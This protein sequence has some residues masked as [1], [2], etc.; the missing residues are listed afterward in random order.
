MIGVDPIAGAAK[1]SVPMS[2]G[3]GLVGYEA[4]IAGDGYAYVPYSYVAGQSDT[5]VDGSYPFIRELDVLRV[6]SSGA[7]DN[8]V[9]AQWTD[10]SGE[11]LS[12]GV[13]TITN[14]DQGV[15]LSWSAPG[16]AAGPRMAMVTGTT[17]AP[18]SP[19]QL[20]NCCGDIAEVTPVLQA[21]DGSF[22]GTAY[23]GD[24]DTP[25]MVSFEAS[26][27]VR[28]TVPNMCPQIATADGGVI[29]QAASADSGCESPLS[30]PGYTFDANGNATGVVGSLPTQSWTGNSYRVGSID[31][32]S[33][34]QYVLATS[35]WAF[36]GGNTSDNYAAAE[37]LP[38]VVK[39]TYDIVQ[40]DPIGS[41][42]V[43]R[44]V[45]YRLFQ[46][47]HTFPSN[48]GAIVS[49][50]LKY[51]SGQQPSAGS[52]EKGKDFDDIIGTRG[53]GPFVLNQ[54][55]VVAIPGTRPYP[56]KIERC[57]PQG[58]WAPPIDENN[59]NAQLKQVLINGDPGTTAGW[60]CNQ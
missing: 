48:N 15:L 29:A 1:F 36:A 10:R 58:V 59:I 7:S 47:D 14:A 12:I 37:P 55:F 33:A 8:I 60:Q 24:V 25:G 53:G 17:A 21:Q 5:L 38:L 27:N 4:I 52:S 22:V 41:G 20:P 54:S 9:V 45:N 28:W 51:I 6:S 43:L 42:A 49:E 19:P 2:G 13:H 26:G 3:Q 30:G 44:N 39:V 35:F 40:P 32:V 23:V 31:L 50:K 34:F 18:V 11:I 46:G 56:I 16:D 57:T